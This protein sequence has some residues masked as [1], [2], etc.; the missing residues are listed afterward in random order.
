MLDMIDMI[1][2]TIN[3]MINRINKINVTNMLDTDQHAR[4]PMV[5]ACYQACHSGKAYKKLDGYCLL[6]LL[7][8]M[9]KG[10]RAGGN[11]I[12]YTNVAY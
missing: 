4:S 7:W 6:V 2:N 11:C 10:E 3:N 9:L 5:R 8:N 12:N 1:N